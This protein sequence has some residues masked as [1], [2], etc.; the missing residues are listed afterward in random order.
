MMDLVARLGAGEG[1]VTAAIVELDA[2]ADPVR[3]AA[4][5]DD[6][7]AVGRRSSHSP[8]RS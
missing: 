8:P 1:G 3:A 7:F 4:E 6:L 5:D 2:L